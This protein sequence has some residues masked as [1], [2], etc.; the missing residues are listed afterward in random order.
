MDHLVP[1]NKECEGD[2]PSAISAKDKHVVIIGGG[3]TR[4]DC[5]GTAHRQGAKSVTQLDYNPGPREYR[6]ESRSPWPMWPIVLRTRLSPAHAEGGARRYEVAVQR[7]LGD[8]NGHLRAMEIAEVK[9]ERDTDGRRRI[10]TGGGSLEIPCEL[11]LLA[12]GFD[13][14]EQLPLLDGPGLALSR[15]GALPCGSD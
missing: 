14:A 1:A 10:T 2:G 4:A 3:D 6:D 7:F 5:L 13:A 8:E 11:A 12:I 9:V 15:R